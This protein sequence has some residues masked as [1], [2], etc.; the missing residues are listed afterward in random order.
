MRAT[1]AAKNSIGPSGVY[2]L[3]GRTTHRP[4]EV[5]S[6][7]WSTYRVTAGW[8][9][10]ELGGRVLRSDLG[11]AVVV[12]V[13]DADLVAEPDERVELP[14]DHALLHRDDRVV[15]DL[16]A[17]GAHLGAALGDV[18][19]PD[20]RRALGQAPAVMGVERVHVELG[21]P[22]E[23]AG[24]GEGRLVLLVVAHDVAGVL[25]QEALDALAELLAAL[26]VDLRHPALAVGIARGRRERRQLPGLLVVERDVGDQVADHREGPHGGHGDR[27]A[28]V[29]VREAGHAQ[30]SWS[31]VDLGAA[32]P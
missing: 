10:P 1:W 13:A 27:L 4:R 2:L 11:P 7:A 19:H 16:D 21:V 5:P 20:A 24:A 9:L 6:A 18:A 32:G 26:D 31:A 28:R 25:A 23:E 30:Q 3:P 15:G 12:L 22:Q 17:L 29:E 8:R 14:V